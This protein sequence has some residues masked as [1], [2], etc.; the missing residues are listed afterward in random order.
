MKYFL[1]IFLVALLASLSFPLMARQA[2]P[3]PDVPDILDFDRR[4]TNDYRFR[5]SPFGGDY[6]GDKLGHSFLTG[7]SAQINF[8]PAL[9]M[10]VDFGYSRASVDATSLLGQSFVTKDV[11]LYDAALVLTK[12][13]AYRSKKGAVEVDLFSLIGG[14]LLRI[15]AGNH[16]TGFIGGGMEIHGKRQWLAWRVEVRNYF[17]SINN[18]GG[19]DFES[20]FTALVG[21]VF[22]LPPAL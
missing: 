11:W 14:G 8:I 4:Q 15:N 10:M 19:S 13:A 16:G 20:D 1:K 21:P 12:P 22:R 5:V 2:R 7:L 6:V 18:P 17:L 9:A 3:E